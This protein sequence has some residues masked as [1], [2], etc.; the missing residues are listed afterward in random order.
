MQGEGTEPTKVYR[1]TPSQ[2]RNTHCHH[3]CSTT[4]RST[5][6]YEGKAER[7]EENGKNPSSKIDKEIQ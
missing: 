6:S 5:Y 2:E 1:D 3:T 4:R 7:A